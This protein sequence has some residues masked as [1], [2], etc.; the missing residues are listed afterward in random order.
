MTENGEA[1]ALPAIQIFWNEAI[2]QT[3]IHHDQEFHNL[4]F[5]L[6]VLEMAKRQVETKIR[7]AQMQALQRAVEEQKQTEAIRRLIK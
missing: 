7:M 4:E 3:A 5:V 6:A 2:K 1:P